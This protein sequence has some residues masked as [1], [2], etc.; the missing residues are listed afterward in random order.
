METIA[1]QPI[2]NAPAEQIKSS[3]LFETNLDQEAQTADESNTNVSSHD[4]SPSSKSSPKLD[5]NFLSLDGQPIYK[6]MVQVSWKGGELLAPTNSEGCLPSI[7]A[8]SGA[9]LNLAV[10]RFDGTYKAIGQ[11]LMPATDGLLTAVSPNI[12]FDSR[13]EQHAGVPGDAEQKIPQANPSDLGDLNISAETAATASS[14]TPASPQISAPSVENVPAQTVAEPKPTTSKKPATTAKQHSST[15]PQHISGK[16]VE[17]PLL[18]KGR[19]EEGNPFAYVSKKVIDWWNSWRMPTLNL[20]GGEDNKGKGTAPATPVAF[21]AAMIKRVEALLAFAKEQTGYSFQ[22]TVNTLN[23]MSSGTFKPEEKRTWDSLGRCYTYVKVALTRCKII[24]GILAAKKLSFQQSDSEHFA[25]QDSASKAGP[26]LLAKGFTEITGSVPDARWAAAGD[27]I[28]YEWSPQTWEK[29]KKRY[30]NPNYPNHGHIDI[31]DYETYI[32]DFIPD[33]IKMRMHPSWSNYQNIRI[34]R[35]DFDLLPTLRIKAFLRCIREF[36]CQEERDDV[37]RY[38]IL[39]TALPNTQGRY[40]SSLAVHPW[41]TVPREHWPRKKEGKSTAAGAYQILCDT[42]QEV[43]DKGLI[44]RPPAG[45]AS[46]TPALQE[47]IAVV[48]MEDRM[49]LHLIRTGKLE[50]AINNTGLNV[51]WSS[52]PGGNEN[53]KRLTADKKPMNMA[54]LKSLFD[55][56]LN[57]EKRKVGL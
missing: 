39:N 4:E 45:T 19:N 20:W 49:A 55:Q 2:Q 15:P 18:E 10:R 54:Y 57:E 14:Q 22:G 44:E 28:V 1:E 23:A 12:V 9:Q 27:V 25:M 40:F 38:Q 37:K 8:P 41:S 7:E 11:C 35:K 5:I 50:E 26:A 51:E 17:K 48:K 43:F 31:R 32:S 42:W 21:D 47:R 46:F 36:E 3:V 34:Y 29:K 53:A 13:T 24:D 30:N 56:Y 16:Q 52:L 33:S 6:M